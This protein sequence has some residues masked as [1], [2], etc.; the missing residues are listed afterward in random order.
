MALSLTPVMSLTPLTKAEK[1]PGSWQGCLEVIHRRPGG[2]SSHKGPSNSVRDTG[3]T[4]LKAN[5]ILAK[6]HIIIH[7]QST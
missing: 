7:D 2:V 5:S 3:I 6:W 1:A 4:Q